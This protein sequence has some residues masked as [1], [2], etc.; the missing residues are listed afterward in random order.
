M[1]LLRALSG[2][3]I[4]VGHLATTADVCVPDCDVCRPYIS[5][6]WPGPQPQT[7]NRIAAT[8]IS[9]IVVLI[10]SPCIKKG[11]HL[12]CEGRVVACITENN[13]RIETVQ[14][15][16][17]ISAPIDDTNSSA[18]ELNPTVLSN[19]RPRG[20]CRGT[21]PGACRTVCGPGRAGTWPCRL[22]SR[23]SLRNNG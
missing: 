22:R 23:T 17:S 16:S 11:R 15:T 20:P 9:I 2:R 18:G 21:G 8:T 10:I 13:R 3:W 6:G 1:L 5:K 12:I 14:A 7:K 19:S 4:L